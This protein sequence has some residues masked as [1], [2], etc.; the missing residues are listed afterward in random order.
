[1]GVGDIL[2]G[3]AGLLSDPK[4]WV[5]LTVGV[6]YGIIAGAMP[7]IGQT[8]AYGLILPFTFALQATEGV[9]LLLATAVGVAYGNSLPAV[10]IGVPGTPSAVLSA[11][12][13]YTM[14]KRGERG[15][16][17]ATQ[18]IAAL[19]GQFVSAIIFV[20]AV[21]P[22]SGLAY[23][24]LPP[25][26]FGLYLLGMVAII[27]LTGKSVL[28]GIAAACVGIIIGLVGMDPLT[29]L[30]RFAPTPDFRTGLDETAI[31]I[32]I[33]AV[34]ELFRQMRQVYQ[35]KVDAAGSKV[36]KF[37]PMSKLRR[38]WRPSIIGT[39]VGTF[40][41][42]IPG[43]GGGG[44]SL[45]SYQQAKIFSKTPEEFG[46]GSIEGL[47]ANEAAQSA[48]NSGEIIPALGLG[49][50]TSGSTV[51]LL[52]ALMMQGVVPGPQML[53]ETPQLL[54]AAV[55]GLIGAT[56]LLVIIGWKTA[57]LMVRVISI[58]RQ[59]VNIVALALVVIGVYSI[60]AKV[61]DVFVCLFAGL[62]GYFMLRYGYSTAALALA[63]IVAPRLESSLRTGLRMEDYDLLRFFGR[64]ITLALVI[65]SVAMLG[66][67]IWSEI[68][69]R[70]K[71][72]QR[73]ME[74][75]GV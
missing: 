14:S 30:P 68:S 10:L 56:V 37:P 59:I 41:G 43:A 62:L 21:I 47:A 12:D 67:G 69:T 49:I 50:P 54:F 71:L 61:F 65:I 19:G 20:F 6:V 26:L 36:P 8:L 74:Q 35:Y 31:V 7:G 24:F 75:A 27:S 45:L 53:R 29:N 5:V 11:L 1:M 18:Y 9:T 52:T 17:L 23:I 2:S 39:L 15:V 70:K 33:L 28:R 64:P 51:L 3:T 34:S 42:A 66:Y 16:A 25:E 57:M 72:R 60:R 32:G 13:G 4:I 22:L 40:V 38:I 55:L 58:D 46:N 44:A 48:A 63:V 73:E